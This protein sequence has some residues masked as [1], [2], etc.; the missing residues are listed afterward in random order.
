[1]GFVV[2]V[3]VVASIPALILGVVIGGNILSN[4]P[5]IVVGILLALGTIYLVREQPRTAL[6]IPAC[7]AVF[8]FLGLLITGSNKPSS[9]ELSIAKKEGRRYEA[10]L[11]GKALGQCK[12]KWERGVTSVGVKEIFNQ[13]WWDAAQIGQITNA[14][15]T[16]E[17]LAS[18]VNSCL[19]SSPPGLGA[20]Q[21][22]LV[23]D[24]SL[25]L[26]P[27]VLSDIHT[28]VD[29]GRR[30]FQLGKKKAN[31][32]ATPEDLYLLSIKVRQ[33]DS[34]GRDPNSTPNTRIGK[35]PG[36]GLGM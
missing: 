29:I 10:L 7:V 5:G 19:E 27:I 31:G 20:R 35:I 12:D 25:G 17:Q 33:L 6:L 13:S 8:F 18:T 16:F 28:T 11:Q 15:T 9:N 23:F 24:A 34:I 21:A 26:Y 32:T 36:T 2:G 14:S 30:A 3:S 22:S 4:I 1:F